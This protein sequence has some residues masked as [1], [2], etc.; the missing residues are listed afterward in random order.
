MLIVDVHGP[1]TSELDGGPTVRFGAEPR[2]FYILEAA[3][4][5]ASR[6]RG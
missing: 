3:N 6:M 1:P 2:R 5:T 4:F